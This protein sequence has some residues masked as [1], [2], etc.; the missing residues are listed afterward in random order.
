[1]NKD[2]KKVVGKSI[3]C[4]GDLHFSDVFTGKHKNYLTNCSKILGQIVAK[5]QSEKP[6]TLVILGDLVGWNETNIRDRQ[7]L[8]MFCKAFQEINYICPIYVVRGNHDMKGY[9]EF[10]FLEQLGLIV[11]SSMCGGYFDYYAN[12]EQTIPEVRFHIVDYK[13]ENNNLELA[14]EGTSNIVLGHNNYTIQ[15]VTNWY[16]EHDGIELGMLQNFSGV[17]MVISGH[18]HNPSPEFVTTQMPNEDVCGLFYAGCP[19]RPIKDKN[20][21][22][23]VWWVNIKYNESTQSTDIMPEPWLLDPASEIFYEDDSFIEEKTDEEIQDEVRKDALV[24]VLQDILQ[25]RILG[26]N[27]IE[28]VKLIPNASDDAKDIAINYLQIALNR[29]A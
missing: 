6:S 10:N 15:G 5:V 25:Y 24:D 21:Y 20:M 7:I 18:I 23:S 12:E 4:I 8:S 27:P 14:T 11:T 17:D 1:M 16:A 2:Y 29:G 13:Q 9:P 19:T 26:G 3:L 28:Q 22:D